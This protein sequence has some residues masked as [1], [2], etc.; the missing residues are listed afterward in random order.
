VDAITADAVFVTIIASVLAEAVVAAVTPRG[1]DEDGAALLQ[2]VGA[3][4]NSGA[5][6]S[7]WIR[8]YNRVV[9]SLRSTLSA[10]P[11][12]KVKKG[13]WKSQKMRETR[14]HF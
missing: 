14:G 5:K 12:L 2:L 9:K 3:A 1:E 13:G 6:L 4:S 11:E 8:T 7:D 10:S